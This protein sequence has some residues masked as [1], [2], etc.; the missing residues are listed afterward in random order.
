MAGR[1]VRIELT[2]IDKTR[3]AF[4]RVKRGLVG[5]GKAAANVTKRVVKF[6][7]ASALVAAGA[8]A[9]LTKSSMASIDQLA[10]VA[11]KLG[12]T[13][14]ALSGM[15]YA[16]EQSGLAVTTFQMASQ[17]LI[18]RLAE[19]ADGGGEAM[20][21]FKE[22]GLNARELNRIPLEQKLGI[23]SDALMGV[24]SPAHRV[25]LA[26]KLFDSEGVAVLNM[27]KHGS[28]GLEEFAREAEHLGV[29]VNRVDAAK[30]EAANEAV[31]RSK[32][33]F[34]GLG[35]QLATAFSPV[36]EEVANMFRQASLDNEDFGDIGQRV[37]MALIKATGRVLDTV[38][39]LK[40]MYMQTKAAVLS[41]AVSITSKLAPALQGF[42]DM[43]NKIAP[44][45]FQDKIESNPLAEWAKTANNDLMELNAE[46]LKLQLQPKPSESLIEWFERVQLAAR[47]AAE[48][49]AKNSPGQVVADANEKNEPKLKGFITARIAGEK[50]LA[51]FQQKSQ[52][53][54]SADVIGTMSTLFAKNKK[55]QI[56]N[57]V[58]QTY[59]AATKALAAYPPPLNFAMMAAVV[60]A[61]MQQVS[62]IK[63]QSME[64][65]GF[66]G[67]GAR[68]GGMDGRGGMGPFILHP[69]ESVVDHSRGGGSIVINNTV[70]ATGADAMVDQKIRVAME[71]ASMQTIAAIG[72]LRRRG[73]GP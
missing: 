65:G 24:E 23:I 56:A 69:N 57:A 54:R 62:T 10:K 71:Q 22:L 16:A 55:L 49:V 39:G 45:I 3:K 70:D 29:T 7:A 33:V 14:T 25:R 41:F 63:A 68:S 58:M 18:R 53:E 37:A 2:A 11:D 67:H 26:F 6:G 5:I 4:N 66:T 36:I 20:L 46:I 42:I 73:R 9:A 35:N 28:K 43:Y 31:N 15:Q 19:A 30:I 17:R 52:A 21:A 59:A 72:D 34:V 48:E 12:V 1:D 13:T 51:E 47:R 64:G 38:L 44:F 8:L 50:Q 27:L 40:I 32:Q 60:A 61:G